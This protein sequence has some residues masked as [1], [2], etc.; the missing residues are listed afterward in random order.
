MFYS[1]KKLAEINGALASSDKRC[2]VHKGKIIA[3]A[4][5]ELT[6]YT[7]PE[8]ITAIGVQAFAQ[9]SLKKVTISESITSIETSAFNFATSLS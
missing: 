5:A 2:L 4:P 1:C 6:E 3:F 8:G 7:I 9:S